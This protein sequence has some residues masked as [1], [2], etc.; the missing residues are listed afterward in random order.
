M[1]YA[2]RTLDGSAV[3]AHELRSVRV[4]DAGDFAD[5]QRDLVAVTTGLEGHLDC[6]FTVQWLCDPR[7]GDPH[8][9]QIEVSVLTRIDGDPSDAKVAEIVD[10]LLDLLNG[11]P[12]VWSFEAVVDSDRLAE[13]LDPWEP[14]HIAGIARREESLRAELQRSGVGFVPADPTAARMPRPDLWSMWTLGPPSIDTHRLSAALLAQ[15]APVS[16]RMTIA[17]T[18]LTGAERE[19]LERLIS[20]TMPVADGQLSVQVAL[21]TLESILYLRPLFE[22]RCVVSSPD[23][24]SVSLL[25]LIGHTISEPT[26]HHEPSGVLVGGYSVLGDADVEDLRALYQGLGRGVPGKGLAVA[27][28]ERVRHLLG[29]WE[30]ANLFRFPVAGDD[31]APGHRVDDRPQLR[32]VLDELPSAGTRIGLLADSRGRP[33]ALGDQDRLRHTYVVG[34]TGTGKST[35]LQNLA[36][37]DIAAGH[38]VCVIDPHGDL[39]EDLL[40]QIPPERIGDVV[41]VDPADRVAVAGVNLLESESFI[42][43]QFLSAELSNLFYALFDPTRSG[44]V[45]PRFESMLRQAVLL[46]QHVD[47]VPSSFLDVSTVFTD[48]A[49]RAFLTERITDPM[50]GEFWLGE[51]PQALNSSQYGDVVSWF[52]SKFEIFRTSPLLRGVVGQTRSTFSFNQVLSENKILLVNLSKGQLGEYNSNLLGHIIVTKLWGSVLERTA[53]SKA[54]RSNFFVYIDEFQNVTTDSL[55]TMLAEAR[56]Y[57]VGLTLANQFFDQLPTATQGALLGN[58]GSKLAFRLGPQ[59]AESFARWLGEGVEAEELSRLSNH[60]LVAALSPGGAPTSPVLIE[61]LPP[62]EGTGVNAA[63]VR[64]AARATWARPTTEV[65]DE[66]NQRWVDVPGSIASRVRS[67]RNQTAEPL[68]APKA[69]ALDEWLAKR[70]RLA[71][72]QPMDWVREWA[73]GRLESRGPGPAAVLRIV[74]RPFPPVDSLV[75]RLEEVTGVDADAFVEALE[76]APESGEFVLGLPHTVAARAALVLLSQGYEASVTPFVRR[77][78]PGLPADAPLDRLGFDPIVLDWLA[79]GGIATVGELVEADLPGGYDALRAPVPLD[80]LLEVQRAAGAAGEVVS[81]RGALRLMGFANALDLNFFDMKAL[82]RLIDERRRDM[83]EQARAAYG[84]D[85]ADS[86]D[87]PDSPERQDADTSLPWDVVLTHQASDVLRADLLVHAVEL[88][89]ILGDLRGRDP[90]DCSQEDPFRTEV[91][92]QMAED[93]RREASDDPW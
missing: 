92:E 9:G 29:V 18:E 47:E 5:I 1:T 50:L 70:R 24:L 20:E 69:S 74:P 6:C 15:E 17:P 22:A 85:L 73:M 13:L 81:H 88:A 26:P 27:G 31:G 64:D 21:R 2:T 83:V 89:Q 25:S 84:P 41:L 4:L 3:V 77:L 68:A 46:L 37:A 45:G 23:P 59:D 54:D 7:P 80:L 38:G 62:S 71:P 44:I 61:T 42:Q 86:H 66:F 19:Q 53:V 82:G 63:S 57:G 8:G 56:K 65:E 40:S 52:R 28:L 11:P 10:D 49:V 55:A 76:G 30:A 91:V 78:D 51:M 16:I 32:A 79:A 36:A 14:A 87:S 35:L 33:V 34:Q 58:V 72:L 43:E 93:E 39:I 90:F 60:Q 48:P 75:E 67:R 12:G